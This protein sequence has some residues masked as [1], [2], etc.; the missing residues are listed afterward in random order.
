MLW[1]VVFTKEQKHTFSL[2]VDRFKRFYALKLIASSLK[3]QL[4][5]QLPTCLLTAAMVNLM[6]L[7]FSLKTWISI[8]FFLLTLRQFVQMKWELIRKKGLIHYMSPDMQALLLHRSIFDVLCDLWFIPRLSL[9]FKAFLMP[10]II[11]IKMRN[12][13]PTPAI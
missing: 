2:Q 7:I 4:A 9:Y 13:F 5:R 1:S 3:S 10:M 6:L 12:I 11:K 8:L